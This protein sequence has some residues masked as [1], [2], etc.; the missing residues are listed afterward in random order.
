RKAASPGFGPLLRQRSTRKR[1]SDNHPRRRRSSISTKSATERA[2]VTG[3]L[4]SCCIKRLG[5]VKLLTLLRLAEDEPVTMV[6]AGVMCP[7]PTGI[8]N[9]PFAN[10]YDAIAGREPHGGC[11]VDQIDVGPLETMPVDVI[12]DFTEEDSLLL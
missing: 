2:L 5:S 4:R 12:S 3:A 8:L 6:A 1:P 10:F 11:P 9:R 7:L